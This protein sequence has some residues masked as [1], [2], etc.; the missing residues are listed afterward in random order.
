MRLVIRILLLTGCSVH[1]ALAIYCM[2][3]F[4]R[5]PDNSNNI[6][7]STTNCN[8]A[9]SRAMYRNLQPRPIF[10]APRQTLTA[11]ASL[12]YLSHQR[13]SAATAHG[14]CLRTGKTVKVAPTDTGSLRVDMSS[15]QAAMDPM[16]D[17]GLWVSRQSMRVALCLPFAAGWAAQVALWGLLGSPS[18][19]WTVIA[20][21]STKSP[22]HALAWRGLLCGSG[23]ARHTGIIVLCSLGSNLH[24]N[25]LCGYMTAASWPQM[26]QSVWELPLCELLSAAAVW[27][28]CP[29]EWTIAQQSIALTFAVAWPA[30]FGS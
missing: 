4:S 7:S 3:G 20:C 21:A 9:D 23:I 15:V 1:L 19:G 5:R 24:F 6:H 10:P 11:T 14:H 22:V 30:F 12:F 29:P 16:L 18:S 2:S 26:P 8:P 17:L 28:L 25:T 13:S 27:D